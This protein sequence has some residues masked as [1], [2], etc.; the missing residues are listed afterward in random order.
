MNV[1]PIR[2]VFLA[3]IEIVNLCLILLHLFMYL[4]D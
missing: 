2:Y 4:I 1:L 3:G